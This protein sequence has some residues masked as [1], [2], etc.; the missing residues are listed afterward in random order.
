MG[1]EQV[2]VTHIVAV[3]VLVMSVYYLAVQIK[4]NTRAVRLHTGY[5]VTE[6]FREF[7]AMS[8][9][10][11]ELSEIYR[12]GLQ[13]LTN[14]TAAEQMHFNLFLHNLCLAYENSYYQMADGA[15]DTRY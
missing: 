6:A 14:I 4:Q 3:I 7:Y 5:N 2:Y 11:G 13:D 1:L 10:N 8:A 15:L 12:N 9:A